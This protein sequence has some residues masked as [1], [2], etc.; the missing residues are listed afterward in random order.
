MPALRITRQTTLGFMFVLI[1]RESFQ[2]AQNGRT[3]AFQ[4]VQGPILRYLVMTRQM[5]IG[6]EA[7][8]K[9]IPGMVVG[10]TSTLSYQ[11]AS[12]SE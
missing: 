4:K 2:R 5:R 6:A 12:A 8:L 9:P 10:T 3:E 7:K 1:F 11:Q